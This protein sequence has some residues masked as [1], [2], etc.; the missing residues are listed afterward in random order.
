ML[1]S[2]VRKAT[3][4]AAY[5]L[6]FVGIMGFARGQTA[7]LVGTGVILVLG[8][9]FLILGNRLDLDY[10]LKLS[11]LV[12]SVLMLG[13]VM[14]LSI[15]SHG[16]YYLREVSY[17][18]RV[19]APGSITAGTD[20]RNQI[21]LGNPYAAPFH[22]RIDIGE[23]G[24]LNIVNVSKV[25]RIEIAGQNI[26][27]E[28]VFAGDTIRIGG[29][30]YLVKEVGLRSLDLQKLG[31]GTAGA[32][33]LFL[34]GE[35]S[36]KNPMT[37]LHWL[38]YN[39]KKLS[40]LRDGDQ[41][42]IREIPLG[43]LT[44][45]DGVTATF[46]F[47]G[48]NLLFIA[49]KNDDDFRGIEVQHAAPGSKKHWHYGRVGEGVK[50]GFTDYSLSYDRRLSTL[51]MTP[52]RQ[53]ASVRLMVPEGRWSQVVADYEDAFR[54]GVFLPVGGLSPG[55]YFL[56][57]QGKTLSLYDSERDSTA[58]VTADR[59]QVLKL[60]TDTAE[61]SLRYVT[62]WKSYCYWYVVL[63]AGILMVSFLL[64]RLKIINE[65]NFVFYALCLLLLTM[66][67]GTLLNLGTFSTDKLMRYA[68]DNVSWI[69][70]LM[71]AAVFLAWP[72]LCAYWSQ[73]KPWR[74]GATAYFWSECRE[75]VEVFYLH[76]ILER[77]VK[78]YPSEV[79]FG[80][81]AGLFVALFPNLLTPAM[82][83][84]LLLAMLL[85]TVGLRFGPLQELPPIRLL[86]W[87]VFSMKFVTLF[88]YY[89][90]LCLIGFQ[91]LFFNESGIALRGVFSFQPV[92][93]MKWTACLYFA[94]Y[95]LLLKYNSQDKFGSVKKLW[96]RIIIGEPNQAR[97][98]VMPTIVI[99]ILIFWM[100]DISPM[101]IIVSFMLLAYLLTF[102]R[103]KSV[104]RGLSTERII[105]WGLLI[106]M[107]AAAFIFFAKT[108]EHTTTMDRVL[109]WVSPWTNSELAEQFI[110]GLWNMKTGGAFGQSF[111][112]D[113]GDVLISSIHNDFILTY[114]IDR[115]G[116]L[117]FLLLMLTYLLY[118]AA[119]V[120]A[121]RFSYANRIHS[122]ECA[123]RRLVIFLLLLVF[124]IQLLFVVFMVLGV[125]PVMGQPLPFFAAG[126]SNLIFFNL[127]SAAT[128]VFLSSTRS[129]E[130][131]ERAS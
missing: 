67:N 109:A 82:A 3:F 55:K 45:R 60:H 92:E 48:N 75:M 40:E 24:S 111:L 9:V 88:L 90:P 102:E 89:L 51:T 25:K 84:A 120:K 118:L 50:I 41:P 108:S 123:L 95:L 5:C 86:R 14:T 53:E 70:T 110:V 39:F 127:L 11:L 124:V 4:V 113:N 6:S 26:N 23:D 15:A 77:D 19:P 83:V 35:V 121:Y 21:V 36:W 16:S 117:G 100:K 27:A 91:A 56:K 99:F 130:T 12:G 72:L 59:N 74:K 69:S 37:L 78:V 22:A 103:E 114:I 44:S 96:V 65:G 2:P 76:Q 58:K 10:R 131:R 85:L 49:G 107:L 8:T 104:A 119:G 42:Y 94:H 81:C 73:P 80:I 68:Q 32:T 106:S 1:Y 66:G 112:G 52:S 98:Y 93:F 54:D 17:S 129:T 116:W 29:D 7:Y 61:T 122:T 38:R 101:L 126:R 18:C 46:F 64:C 33:Q 63:L 20:P 31:D 128:I 125:F 79:F 105:G 43:E 71:I 115:T 34:G 87:R 28:P 57:S 97:R 30:S 47:R 13:L 62:Y